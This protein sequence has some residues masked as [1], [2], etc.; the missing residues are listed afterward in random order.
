MT[1]VGLYCSYMPRVRS[2]RS[3]DQ[4]A[5][6]AFLARYAETSMFLRANLRRHGLNDRESPRATA[7]WLAEESGITGVFGISNAGYVMMQAPGASPGLF[8]AFAHEIAGCEVKGLT[9]VPDQVA[10]AKRALG[11]DAAAVERRDTQQFDAFRP[12][13]AKFARPARTTGI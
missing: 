4:P 2:A 5:I 6:D 12:G 8:S 13:Q 11:L 10:K 9:G 3:G 1:T 7:F